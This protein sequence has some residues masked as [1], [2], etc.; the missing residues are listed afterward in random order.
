[1]AIMI[2]LCQS[3]EFMQV[4]HF[5]SGLA[6]SRCQINVGAQQTWSAWGPEQWSLCGNNPGQGQQGG[7]E[8]EARDASSGAGAE[9][10]PGPLGVPFPTGRVWGSVGGGL[11]LGL[12]LSSERRPHF[13]G[14]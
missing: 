3:K 14:D 13:H 12:R 8:R 11:G 6:C 7:T 10:G 5:A 4:K 9:E 2:N 1:M